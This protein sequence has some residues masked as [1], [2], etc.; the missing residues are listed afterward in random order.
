MGNFV[1]HLANKR[2]NLVGAMDSQ[3]PNDHELRKREQELQEREHALRLRE[4]EAEM[5][6]PPVTPTVK[7]HP[8]E[9]ALQRRLRDLIKTA[10]FIGLIAAAGILFVVVFR[11]GTFLASALIVG[12]VV[13]VAYK[14]FLEHDRPR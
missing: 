13:W 7:H 8:P 4:L 5:M 3:S 12:I 1:P 11:I 2:C 14:L 10:K 9:S 6:Q